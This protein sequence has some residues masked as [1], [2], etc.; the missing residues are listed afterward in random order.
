MIEGRRGR[1]LTL[2]GLRGLGDVDGELAAEGVH[3]HHA[4]VG[5]ATQRRQLVVGAG[6]AVERLGEVG[7]AFQDDLLQDQPPVNHTWSPAPTRQTHLVVVG[8]PVQRLH[9]VSGALQQHFLSD[10][11]EYGQSQEV[12]DTCSQS[13]QAPFTHQPT[14]Q[15]VRERR[16]GGGRTT[17]G[18]THT[19]T[20]THINT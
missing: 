14:G 5:G 15:E 9:Q 20:H 8:H 6:D 3:A 13:E 10:R 7:G 4:R 17:R 1:S 16:R 19:D 11:R 12:C 18:K 2:L